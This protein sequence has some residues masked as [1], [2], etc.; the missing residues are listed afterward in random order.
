VSIKSQ[1]ATLP[2]SPTI[3]IPTDWQVMPSD[4]DDYTLDI[5][6]L[7]HYQSIMGVRIRT[8]STLRLDVVYHISVLAQGTTRPTEKVVE[9]AY[10]VMGYQVDTPNICYST[11]AY[12]DRIYTARDSSFADDRQ[13]RKSQQGHLIFYNVAPIIWKSNRQH[14]ID[15]CSLYN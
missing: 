4:W 7:K 6:L 8:V 5:K 12:P 1:T 14:T 10:R 11:P 9:S 13:T 15:D 3:P 2:I